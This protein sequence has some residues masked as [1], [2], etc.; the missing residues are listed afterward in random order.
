MRKFGLIGYPLGHS[1]SKKYFTEK[2]SREEITD[3]VY[4]NYPLTSLDQ[5]PELIHNE[6]LEGLNVT[7]PYKSAVI[8]YL[9]K[10]DPEAD[11]IG[12][13]NV[14]RIVRIK[15]KTEMHGF[16]SDITGIRNTLISAI[17]PAVRNALVLGTGGSSKS[18]CYVL[19]R[20]NIHYTLI[21]R[22]KKS[23]CLTYHDINSEI[24]RN[25]Q[26]IINTTPLGMYPDTESKPDIKYDLLDNNHILFDLVYNPE[27]TSFLKMGKERGC[28]ILTGLKMLYSQADRSWEIWNSDTL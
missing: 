14:I 10:I 3:C 22:E 4:D 6:K 20:I 2:F 23:G 11:T 27:I 5:L 16:N 15:D 7:I 24:I 19:K 8:K 1:F 25:A 21:S 18:V 17:T 26:L 28:T 13:V 9:D 12:A